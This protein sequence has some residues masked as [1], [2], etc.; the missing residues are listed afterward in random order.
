MDNQVS[1]GLAFENGKL[2]EEIIASE[3]FKK[4]SEGCENV[5]NEKGVHKDAKKLAKLVI[6]DCNK[7]LLGE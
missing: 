6:F 1:Y 4:I 7:Y 5:I 2:H 3:L